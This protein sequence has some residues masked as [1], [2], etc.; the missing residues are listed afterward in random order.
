MFG[1]TEVYI[2]GAAPAS[3]GMLDPIHHG[4]E[5]NEDYYKYTWY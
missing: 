3:A 5:H 1:T 4:I 2:D